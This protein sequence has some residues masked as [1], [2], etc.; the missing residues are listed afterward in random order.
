MLANVEKAGSVGPAYGLFEM[1][2]DGVLCEGRI[3]VDLILVPRG[4]GN[5][6]RLALAPSCFRVSCV[7][8]REL[9][10]VSRHP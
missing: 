5:L 2:S 8:Q 7:H 4:S 9:L 6:P 1:G 3:I 10:A